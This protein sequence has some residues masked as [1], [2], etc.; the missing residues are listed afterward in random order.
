MSGLVAS[1]IPF[2][3]HLIGSFQDLDCDMIKMK[4]IEPMEMM[5]FNDA[6]LVSQ[7]LAGRREA[8]GRIVARYQSSIC[9]LS[10]SATGDSSKARTWP[11]K[12]SSRPGRNWANCANLQAPRLALPHLAQSNL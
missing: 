9:A 11:R 2:S 3:C 4:T 10:Y 6:D 5:D 7:S 12:P 8:F 1:N